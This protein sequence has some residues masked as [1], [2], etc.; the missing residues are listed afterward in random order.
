MARTI[1]NAVVLFTSENDMD[2][3]LFRVLI[4]DG[5]RRVTSQDPD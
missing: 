3:I 4:R 2:E 5:V 1:C